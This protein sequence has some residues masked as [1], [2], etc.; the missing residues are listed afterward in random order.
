MNTP[1]AGVYPTKTSTPLFC[2][3]TSLGFGA[4]GWRPER[5]LGQASAQAQGKFMLYT[6]YGFNQIFNPYPR[7]V[8]LV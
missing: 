1:C 8:T 2:G 6:V 7:L 3:E 4:H 5:T